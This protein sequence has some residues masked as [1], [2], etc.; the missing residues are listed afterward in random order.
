MVKSKT[1]SSP[2]NK[3]GEVVVVELSVTGRRTSQRE[4]EASSTSTVVVNQSE[5][6]TKEEPLDEEDTS[7]IT[8][9]TE[10]PVEMENYIVRPR[11]CGRLQREEVLN[12]HDSDA[13]PRGELF[14]HFKMGLN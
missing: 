4:R 14:L 1:V 8:T 2:A 13:C 9:S 10:T 12:K 3:P 11:R 7:T 5:P 6:P